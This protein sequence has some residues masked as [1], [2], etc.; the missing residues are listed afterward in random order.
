MVLPKLLLYSP[1]DS[2]R[3]KYIVAYIFDQLLQIPAQVTSSIPDFTQFS[4]YRINYSKERIEG[5]T[6]LRLQPANLL[7]ENHI[8]EQNVSTALLEG[9]P[10]IYG[11]PPGNDLAFDPLAASFFVLSRYEEY[12]EYVPDEHGRYSAVHSWMYRNN[13]LKTPIVWEWVQ[14]LLQALKK[15]YPRLSY[16]SPGYHFAPTYDVDIPWAFRHRGPRGIARFAKELLTLNIPLLHARWQYWLGRTNDPYDTFDLLRDLHQRR[17]LSTRF[18][19]LLGT[20]SRQDVNPSPRSA[21]YQELIQ[22]IASWAAIGIHPSY[23]SFHRKDKLSREINTLQN[24]SNQSITHSRQHY[25]RFNLPTTY[26]QLIDA[27]IQ[28]DY[29]MGF[30][31]SIGYR[32]GTSEAFPW[33]DVEKNT[34]TTLTIHPFAAMEV[35]LKQYEA[36]SPVAAQ[37]QLLQMQKYSQQH[38]LT[39]STLWHNSSFSTVHG[40]TGWKKVYEALFS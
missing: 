15:H 39:F 16:K 22:S 4:G 19:F 26:R 21:A 7:F 28:H 18:F 6:M 10:I 20:P 11:V 37:E 35:S 25:L 14:L 17:E 9:K 30:A 40:W 23:Q 24:I 3:L 32:A 13:C 5:G 12:L 29:S 33:F 27:G 8:G 2:A 1:H 34:A 38:G 36:A 31:D